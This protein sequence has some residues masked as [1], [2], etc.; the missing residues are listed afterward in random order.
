M[1]LSRDF[2][3]YWKKG[4]TSRIE[5]SQAVLENAKIAKTFHR[6]RKMQMGLVNTNPKVPDTRPVHHAFIRC[7]YQ[8]IE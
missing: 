2:P 7:K 8:T 5:P 4:E 6:D 3:N 1:L